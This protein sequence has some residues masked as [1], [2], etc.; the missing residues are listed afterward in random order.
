MLGM[1]MY[2]RDRV[3]TLFDEVRLRAG[4]QLAIAFDDLGS[5]GLALIVVP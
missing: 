3:R 1:K 5:P 2:G 4:A